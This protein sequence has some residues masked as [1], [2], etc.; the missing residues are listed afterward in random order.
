MRK[1]VV[2]GGF[3]EKADKATR[4]KGLGIAVVVHDRIAESKERQTAGVR[5]TCVR[6][7]F[8]FFPN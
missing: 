2:G 7:V 1:E 3:P 5:G 4:L 8:E 6:G